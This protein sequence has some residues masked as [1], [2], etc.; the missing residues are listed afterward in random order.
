MK[1]FVINLSWEVEKKQRIIDECERVGLDV[2]IYNAVDG[3]SL[4][5]PFLRENVFDYGNNF[6]TKGEIGCSL[7]HINLYKRIVDENVPFALIMEDDATFDSELVRFLSA[8]DNSKYINGGIYLLTGDVSYV[9]NRSSKLS[10]F[11]IHQVRSATRTTGYVITN[12]AAREM[13]KIL[14]PV[15][16]E[17]D[18]Y[19]V[20]KKLSRVSIYATIPH[21][22]STNDKDKM[23]SSLEAERSQLVEKR[24]R[25]RGM[26]FNK[27][28]GERKFS[29]KASDFFWRVFI[30]GFERVR[31]YTQY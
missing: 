5:E 4:S 18:M 30:R 27:M 1:A 10:T 7:S 2:E 24:E 20:F 17:A 28:K 3:G 29:L 31:R 22:I 23:K 8:F 19:E 26:L 15:R 6:L 11:K 13:L 21:L 25:Y 9:E 16:F 12:C 14:L